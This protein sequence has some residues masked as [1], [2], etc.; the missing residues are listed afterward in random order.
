MNQV[1]MRYNLHHDLQEFSREPQAHSAEHLV[2]W[3]TVRTSSASVN[4]HKNTRC[5]NGVQN[6][7]P[8][9][10]KQHSIRI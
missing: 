5:T 1:I 10:V 2:E 6:Q 3:K 9:T 4:A 7:Y 8:S